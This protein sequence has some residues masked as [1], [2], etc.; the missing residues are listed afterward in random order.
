MLTPEL[1]QLFVQDMP[2]AFL[3]IHGGRGRMGMTHIRLS[4]ATEDVLADALRAAW[5]LRVEKN[6]K[7]A[8]KSRVRAKA[9]RTTRASR[10]KQ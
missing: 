5:K 4:A 8:K 1:Q 2:E 3:R 10:K 7:S 9:K 6:A